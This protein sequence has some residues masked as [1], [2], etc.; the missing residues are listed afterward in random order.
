MKISWWALYFIVGHSWAHHFFR[1]R[2]FRTFSSR[3]AKRL[4][5]LK[6]DSFATHL[7]FGAKWEM[8]ATRKSIKRYASRKPQAPTMTID[9]EFA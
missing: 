1:K 4:H 7:F 8:A 3:I 6:T 9:N 5:F 2:T